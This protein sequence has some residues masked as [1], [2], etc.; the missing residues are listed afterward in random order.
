M[1]ENA[2][3]H[4][5]RDRGKKPHWEIVTEAAREVGQA[6]FFS[7]LI[8]ALAFLPVF[9]LTGQSGRM[10]EPLAFTK[11]YSMA[12]A[13]LLS[14]TLVPVLM[15]YLIRG[16]IRP[17]ARNPL[18]RFFL[19]LYRPVLHWALKLR[20]L[21]LVAALAVFA[22]TI[23]PYE[24]MGSE[25]IPPLNEGDL[26]YM[27]SLLPGISITEAQAIAEQANRVILHFP[28]VQHA[29][30]KIGRSTSPLDPAPLSMMETTMELEPQSEWPPGMTIE[31]LT[32]GTNV[33]IRFP[34][35]T[36]A[37]TMPIKTRI[38][39]LATGIKTPVGV[40]LTGP[41]LN[42]LQQLGERVKPVLQSLPGT[43]SV[44]AERVSGGYLPRFRRQARR[45]R[46]VWADGRRRR[47]C[48]RIGNRRQNI[49]TVIAGLERFPIDVRYGRE[50]ATRR[51]SC[52]A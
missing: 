46:A 9:A 33:A 32:S 41:D 25:L 44:Y 7:L 5:E 6:L 45:G 34:G 51:R 48:H 39:M 36:N 24:R 38:D 20:W 49:S 30:T 16:R 43:R 47:G 35:V 12:A 3:K 13:A 37:W 21:V 31:K 27:P 29:L 18:N 52:D 11:T 26:L 15:G 40:K 1:I 4:L 42:V 17:E 8:I 2:H 14:M 50:C 23:I 19:W 28:K 22:L 10:F